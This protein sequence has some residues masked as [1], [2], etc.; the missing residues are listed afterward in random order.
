M[1]A[2]SGMPALG[3]I[4]GAAVGTIFGIVFNAPFTGPIVGVMIGSRLLQPRDWRTGAMTGSLIGILIGLA[5][6]IYTLLY[7]QAQFEPVVWTNLILATVMLYAVLC[8]AG[9]LL[10]GWLLKLIG[11]R[12][13]FL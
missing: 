5:I 7:Q 11:E 6:S 9:G 12:K 1:T 2:K 3:L 13:Y 8:A 4:S 10:A